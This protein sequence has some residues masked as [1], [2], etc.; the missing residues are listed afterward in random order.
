MPASRGP[1]YARRQLMGLVNS[2]PEYTESGGY[3]VCARQ[4]CQLC[5][6]YAT[7]SGFAALYA[8]FGSRGECV[9][10][11]RDDGLRHGHSELEKDRWLQRPSR[12]C[13]LCRG[14]FAKVRLTKYSHWWLCSE[15]LSLIAEV[16]PGRNPYSV[17]RALVRRRWGQAPYR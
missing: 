13:E 8:A 5:G 15:C 11:R 6:A 16:A 7:F 1:H 17:V 12:W 4:V 3:G 10:G 9:G 2:W 14:R